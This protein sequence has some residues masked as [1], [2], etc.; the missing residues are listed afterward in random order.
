MNALNRF[1]PF[2]GNWQMDSGER[3]AMVALLEYIRPKCSLEIGS[4]FG[5]SLAVLS[6]YSQKVVSLDIDPTVA[7]RLAHFANARFVVGDSQQTLPGVLRELQG[8]DHP[9]EFAL[10]DGDHSERGAR[11]DCR[12]FLE[13]RPSSTLYIVIHDSFNP[14]VRRGILGVD[15]AGCPYVHAIDVDAVPGSMHGG[16]LHRQMWG[17]LALAVLK[18]EPR[19]GELALNRT[20]DLGFRTLKPLSVHSLFVRRWTQLRRL[21]GGRTATAA[22]AE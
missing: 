18:P 5:G 21:L 8:S 4:K 7:Q 16:D 14:D 6:H 12:R 19:T 9:L 13:V 17:G 1:L 20:A 10:I 2:D 11:E 3:L 15:W 22:A